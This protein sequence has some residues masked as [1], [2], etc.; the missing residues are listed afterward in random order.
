MFQQIIIYIYILQVNEVK[1]KQIKFEKLIKKEK[2][3]LTSKSYNWYTFIYEFKQNTNDEQNLLTKINEELRCNYPTSAYENFSSMNGIGY[4]ITT[5]LDKIDEE[6]ENLQNWFKKVQF[7]VDNLKHRQNLTDD[8]IINQIDQLIRTAFEC[9]LNLENKSVATV[10][11][12]GSK[13]KKITPKICL[14]CEIKENLKRYECI[15]FDKTFVEGDD[16]ENVGTWNPT[17]QESILK[18][19][20]HNF[21]LLNILFLI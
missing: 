10:V 5:W 3:K 8:T 18:S 13:R 21:L 12:N 9:H 11:R 17:L 16:K 1:L 7:F 19:T 2:S 20:I 15:I 4:V 6:R 14:L